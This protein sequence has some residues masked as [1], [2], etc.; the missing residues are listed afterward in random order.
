METRSKSNMSTNKQLLITDQPVSDI[1]IV[2]SKVLKTISDQMKLMQ[3][4]IQKADNEGAKGLNTHFCPEMFF[5]MPSEDAKDWID[6][7]IAWSKLNRIKDM[8]VCTMPYNFDSRGAHI[9]CF[10]LWYRKEF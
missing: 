8:D 5:G 10:K 3:F 7:C 4:Q 9:L 2:L 6:K 1:Q